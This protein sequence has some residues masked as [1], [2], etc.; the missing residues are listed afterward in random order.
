MSTQWHAAT[1]VGSSDLEVSAHRERHAPALSFRTRCFSALAIGVT[2]GIIVYI[3]L[4]VARVALAWDFTWA[5]RAARSILERLDPYVV[6]QPTGEFPFDA[7]F[8]YP[9]PAALISLPLSRL[10]PWLAGSIF[11][12]V[13]IAL[14]VFAL[15]REGWWRLTLLGSAPLL[16]AALS[17]QWSP[18]ITAA[19]L[20]P[21]FGALMI[22]KPTIGIALFAAWPRRATVIGCLILSVI[23]L[24]LVPRWPLEWLHIVL[25]NSEPHYRL[26]IRTTI[27]GPLLLLALLRWRAPEARLLIVMA[28]VPQTLVFYDQLPLLL[29]PRT[30]RELQVATVCSQL[31]FLAAQWQIA[32]SSTWGPIVSI[33][34]CMAS[35]YL[36]ALIILLRHPNSGA[37][38]PRVNHTPSCAVSRT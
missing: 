13:G 15:T 2:F 12:G 18:I 7:P 1:V 35:C 24:T 17:V 11:A 33:P 29:I 34:W 23:A 28:C 10:H 27:F 32:H 36:P 14:L 38:S 21:A 22:A 6:I 25:A 9:L 37:L 8:K 31:G 26:P 16:T 30:A 3:R 4:A 5:W 19:A 20:L